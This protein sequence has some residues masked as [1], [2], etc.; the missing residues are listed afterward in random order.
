MSE[1]LLNPV[2]PLVSGAVVA[3]GNAIPVWVVSG[4]GASGSIGFPIQSGQSGIVQSGGQIAVQSGG[5][6][7]IQQGGTLNVSGSQASMGL[8]ANATFL[9]GSDTNVILWGGA[10]ETVS[11][12]SFLDV[13]PGASARIQGALGILNSGVLT[14]LNGGTL[15]LASGSTLNVSAGTTIGSVTANTM[16][17]ALT[18]DPNTMPYQTGNWYFQPQPAANSAVGTSLAPNALVAIPFFNAIPGAVFTSMGFFANSMTTGTSAMF[19]LYRANSTGSTTVPTGA[20]LVAGTGSSGTLVASTTSGLNAVDFSTVQLSVGWY[21]LAYNFS[22]L[23]SG[24][25]YNIGAGIPDSP[26]NINARKGQ[27]TFGSAQ[28]GATG[29]WAHSATFGNMPST[30]PTS[31]LTAMSVTQLIAVGMKAA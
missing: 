22:V 25:S 20:T 16:N 31:A 4:G 19:G 23:T 9:A 8:T 1:T 24:L 21:Y 30:F 2:T 3:S 10:T 28:A 17:A 18:N 11:S 15:T 6:I 12:G 14:V 27:S 26:Y 29:G 5:S 13:K 7:S